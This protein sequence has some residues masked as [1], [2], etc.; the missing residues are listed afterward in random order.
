MT[1][2]E[3]KANKYRAAF[4]AIEKNDLRELMKLVTVMS[5]LKYSEKCPLEDSPFF[6]SGLIHAAGETVHHAAHPSKAPHL[7]DDLIHRVAGMNHYGQIVA[8]GQP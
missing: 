7:L 4:T 2:S 1:I 6:K 5:N 3:T 8:A